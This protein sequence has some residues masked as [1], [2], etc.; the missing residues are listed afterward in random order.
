MSKA[1]PH[2]VFDAG[3]VLIAT[4]NDAEEAHHFAHQVSHEAGTSLPIEVE[5][6]SSRTSRLVWPDRCRSVRWLAL[7]RP[8]PCALDRSSVLLG[9]SVMGPTAEMSSSSASAAPE[10]HAARV[11]V[12]KAG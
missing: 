11:A 3:N 6:R 10:A 4:F 5:D 9:A 2:H 12:R 1:S 7:E 8:D